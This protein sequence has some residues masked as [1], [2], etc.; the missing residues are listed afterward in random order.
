[1]PRA[2]CEAQLTREVE[3]ERIKESIKSLTEQL[4]ALR[5]ENTPLNNIRESM[6][7]ECTNLGVETRAFSAQWA[8]LTESQSRGDCF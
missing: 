1:V 2:I 7:R 5:V 3:I 8:S 6:R 4:E